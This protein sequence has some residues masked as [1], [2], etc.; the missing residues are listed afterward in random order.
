MV[1]VQSDLY[2]GKLDTMILRSGTKIPHLYVQKPARVKKQKPLSIIPSLFQPQEAPV[3]PKSIKKVVDLSC[4]AAKEG[5]GLQPLS[6][7]GEPMPLQQATK[8]RIQPHMQGVASQ[9]LQ[10]ISSFLGSY[11][12]MATFTI[13]CKATNGVFP[14]TFIGNNAYVNGILVKFGCKI[15]A[16]PEHY[17]KEILKPQVAHSITSLAFYCSDAIN[18]DTIKNLVKTFPNLVELSFVKCPC[19]YSDS[20]NLLST[21][22]LTKLS[23]SRCSGIDRNGFSPLAQ[24]PTLQH[25]DL[26]STQL[27]DNSSFLKS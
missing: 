24:I 22:K 8:P 11:K 7:E 27:H 9:L 17:K 19:I 12:D 2:I 5:L 16:I 25:L 23:L 3:S 21:L 20:L 14:K 10:L 4:S 15:E 6:R 13:A 1:S 18:Y 26:S